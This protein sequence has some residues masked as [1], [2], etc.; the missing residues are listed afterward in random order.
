MG[1]RVHSLR[2]GGGNGVGGINF[3]LKFKLMSECRISLMAATL[4]LDDPARFQM[5]FFYFFLFFG[6]IL[7]ERI[8]ISETFRWREIVRDGAGSILIR[9]PPGPPSLGIGTAGFRS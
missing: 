1:G 6:T 2:T 3:M 9:I 4:S 8:G 7:E 5:D